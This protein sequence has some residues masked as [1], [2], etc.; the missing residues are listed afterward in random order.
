VDPLSLSSSRES[1]QKILGFPRK[2]IFQAGTQDLLSKMK[3]KLQEPF[4]SKFQSALE[5]DLRKD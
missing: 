1:L 5:Q 3:N 2:R 4:N